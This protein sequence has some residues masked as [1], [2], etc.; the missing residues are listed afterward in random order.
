MSNLFDQTVAPVQLD[1]TKDFLAELVGEGKKFKDPKELARGKAHSDAHIANLE[2]TLN[3]MRVEL[4]TRKTAE[5]LINRIT[6]ANNRPAPTIDSDDTPPEN[7]DT[8]SNPKGLTPE[9]VERM[10]QEREVRSRKE[11]NLQAT[12]NKLR[13][14]H[15]DDA[16]RVLQ[17]K[18]SELG[19]DTQ[20]LKNLAQD[21][22]SIFL[23][24]FNKP[25]APKDIFNAPPPS[26][27]RVQIAT[28][29]GEKWS[30]FQKVKTENPTLYW[31]AKFQRQMMD[32][33]ERAAN[34]DTYDKFMNN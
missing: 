9:D 18:A 1:D 23:S 5:D 19:V 26:S 29:T 20:Y 25:E 31:S 34:S 28:Y 24:L 16:A 4:N 32:S 2:K 10:F 8:Q 6:L 12:T 14:L 27:H 15:G 3:E 22:P 30:D 33:A 11:Q 21:S 13:E 17:T 7:R